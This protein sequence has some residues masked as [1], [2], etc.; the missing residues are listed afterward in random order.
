[1]NTP[2]SRH[3]PSRRVEKPVNRKIEVDSVRRV[4]DQ[5]LS[6]YLLSCMAF[7][8]YEVVRVTNACRKVGLFMFLRPVG[9]NKVTRR[10]A[11]HAN[12][13]VNKNAIKPCKRETSA[14]RVSSL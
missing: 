2:G 9:I 3:K 6:S 8:V 5:I 11:S 14:H 10:Q 13:F 1:M 7:S 4:I 12:D